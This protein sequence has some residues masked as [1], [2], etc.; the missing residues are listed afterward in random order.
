MTRDWQAETL[1]VS[2][3]EAEAAH[4][5]LEIQATVSQLSA[6]GETPTEEQVDLEA[7]AWK[8]WQDA[9]RRTEEFHYEHRYWMASRR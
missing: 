7:A 8:K 2:E 1:H 5:Y 6:R 3:A 4:E 9:R